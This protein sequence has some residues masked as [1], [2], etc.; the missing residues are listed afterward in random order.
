MALQE[1]SK[2]VGQERTTGLSEDRGNG[3]YRHPSGAEAILRVD[4]VSG[5]ASIDAYLRVGYVRVGD[6]PVETPVAVAPPV[7][8]S[9]PVTVEG[10]TL[11]TEMEASFELNENDYSKTQLIDMAKQAGVEN[12]EK[13]PNKAALV[14]AIAKASV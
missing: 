9:I 7:Q 1:F 4:P 13:L 6:I 2:G 11:S 8:A 12:A 14:E 10:N 5:T 3:L